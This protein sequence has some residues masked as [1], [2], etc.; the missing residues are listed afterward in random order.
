M[1]LGFETIKTIVCLIISYVC[2]SLGATYIEQETVTLP[3]SV[4]T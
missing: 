4:L 1:P 3:Y 2:G